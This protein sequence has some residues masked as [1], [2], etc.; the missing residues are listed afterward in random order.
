MRLG[1][2][3]AVLIAQTLLPALLFVPGVSKVRAASRI[4]AYG[5]GLIAWAAIAWRG[6]P[7]ERADRF[8]ARPW[9][10]AAGLWLLLLVASPG[11]Y[12]LKAGTAQ[13]LLYLSVMAPAFW[14][15][16]EV[17]SPKKIGRLLAVLFVCNALSATVGLAQVFRPTTFNPPV[18]PALKDKFG[19]EQLMYKTADGRKLLRPCGLTDSPGAA[20]QA[21]MIAA[22][23]GIAYAARPGP[24]WRRVVCAGLGF[25]GVA[26]I[27]YS[28]VRFTMVMLAIGFSA[29]T[30]LLL[31]RGRIGTAMM[32]VGGGL[33][34]L[35]GG[36]A[37]AAR[38]VGWKAV[39]RFGTLLSS[40]PS[41]VYGKSRGFY[42]K[43]AFDRY[44][45]EYP[46]G[47]GLGWWGMVH[48]AFGEP[49][50]ISRVWVEVMIPGWVIDGGAPL[51]IAY[52]GAI[53]LALWDTARVALTSRDE[54]LAFGACVVFALNLAIAAACFSY[55]PFVSSLGLQFWALAATVHA[56]DRRVARRA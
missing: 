31:K 13:A 21:G 45:W 36:F 35:V 52:S 41:S 43:E 56:A 17:E 53:A 24:M 25:A 48:Q 8:P 37:W 14:A 2:M 19:G 20:A 11:T 50:R 18:I 16:G 15:A 40:D 27:Y 1:W 28:Q 12:S 26:V 49:T 22:L 6:V 34:S 54:S 23:I 47:M 30:A 55:L 39:E 29:L 33:G 32:L 4:L 46:L 5:V 42:V 44:L 7:A 3:E 10:F 9:L 38:S 51:L